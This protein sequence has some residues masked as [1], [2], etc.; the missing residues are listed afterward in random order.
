MSSQSVAQNVLRIRDSK[1][2]SVIDELATLLRTVWDTIEA[3]R[4]M[5]PVM[6]MTVA[7]LTLPEA[8]LVAD[9]PRV[10]YNWVLTCVRLVSSF[11][12]CLGV[13]MIPRLF[14]RSKRLL[15]SLHV[16]MIS[17]VLEF[18]EIGLMLPLHVLGTL[19]GSMLIGFSFVVECRLNVEEIRV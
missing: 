4:A 14:N 6:R 3:L 7:F 16:C 17:S 11:G 8:A 9:L 18:G 1:Y 13:V 2:S 12:R 15:T 5:L 19:K 10:V